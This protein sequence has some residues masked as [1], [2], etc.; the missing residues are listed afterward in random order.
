MDRLKRDV[1]RVRQRGRTYVHSLADAYYGG[2]HGKP[3]SKGRAFEDS[4][5]SIEEWASFLAN[6]AVEGKL[7]RCEPLYVP[8]EHV[9]VYRTKAGGFVK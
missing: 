5:I 1:L 9:F 2:E 8:T 4:D 6:I 3:V 7:A